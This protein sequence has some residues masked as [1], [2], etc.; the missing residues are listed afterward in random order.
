MKQIL[1]TSKRNWTVSIDPFNETHTLVVIHGIRDVEE[2]QNQKANL[3]ILALVE[4]N[5]ENF[6]ALASRYRSIIKNKNWKNIQDE[7]NRY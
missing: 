4:E 1:N 2:T 5:K 6:V 3:G 7:R